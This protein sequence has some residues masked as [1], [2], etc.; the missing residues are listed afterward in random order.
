MPNPTDKTSVITL[1][2]KQAQDLK[3]ELLNAS[4]QVV[5]KESKP[6]AFGTVRIPLDLSSLDKGVY[7]LR[8]HRA[9]DI[10]TQRVV[11]R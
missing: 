7:L 8:M 4:G 2:L 6:G 9:G 1:E 10:I 3:L 5:W 11:K